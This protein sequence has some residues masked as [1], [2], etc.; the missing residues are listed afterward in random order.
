MS[1][2][3]IL[4]GPLHAAFLPS[5]AFN[6]SV[7]SFINELPAKSSD[8]LSLALMKEWYAASNPLHPAL[9]FCTIM[10]ALVWIVGELTGELLPFNIVHKKRK[11]VLIRWPRTTITVRGLTMMGID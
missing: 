1:F 8:Y 2:A 5:Y 4:G 9:L 11:R 7:L 3:S 6:P 10:S